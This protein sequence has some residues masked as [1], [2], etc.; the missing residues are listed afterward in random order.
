MFPSLLIKKYIGLGKGCIWG[1]SE[2]IITNNNEHG[3]GNN[4]AQR[5]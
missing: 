4:I 2:N 3:Y 5:L 1:L